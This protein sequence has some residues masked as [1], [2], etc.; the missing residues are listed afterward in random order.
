[1]NL[2]LVKQTATWVFWRIAAASAIVVIV[3]AAASA[4]YCT[5]DQCDECDLCNCNLN[6]CYDPPEFWVINTRCSPKCNNLDAG[7]ETLSYK[8]WD[9]ECRRWVKEIR[10]SF[11]AQEASMPTMF[12]SHGNTLKHGPAME[13]A[14]EVYNRMRCCPGQKRLVFWSWPAQIVYKRPLLR[15]REVI[16]KNLRIKLVYAEYQGYY[17]AKLVQQMSMTQRVMLAG[18]S[19][20]GISAATAAHWLGGGTLRGITLEGGQPVEIPNLRLGIV[21]GAFDN[22]AMIPGCRY[23]Q[24]FVTA[25][26]VYVTRN[27]RDKTLD[28]WPRVSYRGRKAVGVT[29]INANRLGQYRDKLCQQTLTADV[30]RSH[31]LGPHLESKRFVASLCCLAFPACTN[32]G[33]QADATASNASDETT[34]EVADRP[35]ATT[36]DEAQLAD[37]DNGNAD[38]AV[39]EVTL[40]SANK[41]EAVDSKAAEKH[42]D[43]A[44]DVAAAESA[45]RQD[46]PEDAAA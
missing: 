9:P 21:S 40:I 45:K 31:Y 4:Q 46:D 22:D 16:L 41:K 25:N 15:P 3:A 18:H 1:M 19:Y 13:S 28:N 37:A 29:G 30:G 35:A 39:A 20:G 8:R 6:C 7:F 2:P 33:D 17:M 36:A 5:P 23:S 32:C 12:F 24:A 10:E 34:Y 26:K 38:D 27:C 43:E 44:E 14:W 11:L 42:R